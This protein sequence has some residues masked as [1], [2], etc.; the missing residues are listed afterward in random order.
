MNNKIKAASAAILPE[1]IEN[2]QKLIRIPS[3]L[4]AENKSEGKPFGPGV[5]DAIDCFLDMASEIGLRTFKDPEGLYGYAEIGPE[6]T[7]LIGIFGHVD[8]VPVGDVTSWKLAKPYS[9]DIVDGSIIGRG[10]IDDKGP[11][12]VN[13]MA[14]K[15]LIDLGVD[16]TKRV[17]LFVGGAEETTFECIYKYTKI[18]EAPTYSYTP[19]ANFPLINAEKGIF[20]FDYDTDEQIDFTLIAD[21]AYNA[22][23]DKAVYTG[24]KAKEVAAELENLGFTFK[25][26]GQEVICLGK[27]A[28]S[29]DAQ[30]GVNA[31]TRLAMAMDNV[32]ETSKLVHL[33]AKYI[34]D[35]KHGQ[36]IVGDVQDDVS[37]PLT[38]NVGNCDINKQS[39]KAGL[40]TRIPVLCD[41]D[42]IIKHFKT[43]AEKL[44]VTFTPGT[45]KECLYFDANS[46]LVK[47][48]INVY[49]RVTGKENVKPQSTGGG[50]YSRGVDNCVA[51]GMVFEEE[52][53]V[54]N[55][56]QADE[57]LE[58]KYI[59]PALEIYANAI[60]DFLKL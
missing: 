41:D 4:D 39:Q 14:V 12:V 51:F 49:Q 30:I 18:E 55:M 43:I 44:D 56:H 24:N 23:S 13:L 26:D 7:E 50:T 32:G 9:A 31:I 27:A 42:E 2:I 59:T 40:N 10:T 38:L 25:I 48:L 34:G 11:M 33:L 20:N 1:T 60:N 17:R 16:F 29:A 6:N 22:V 15:M 52:G 35:E 37:G 3:V 45:Y 8:V 19:D 58:I 46:D 5:S 54:A 53:Q 47:T 28:H 21:G 36:S 57:A